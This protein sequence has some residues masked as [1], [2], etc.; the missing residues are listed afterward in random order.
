LTDSLTS[1]PS[2]WSRTL[3]GVAPAILL[4]VVA[5]AVGPRLGPLFRPLFVAGCGAA[6]WYAWRSGPYAH[7]QAALFLF[8]FAPLARRIVDVSAG[9]DPTGLML[10]GP[11]LAIIVPLPQLRHYLEDKNAMPP[12]MTPIL[13]TAGCVAYAAAISLFQGDWFNAASGTLKWM[14][15]LVYASALLQYADRE[16]L[17]E[18]MTSAFLVILPITGLIGIYQYIDPPDW[19]RYWMQFAPILSVGR[20]LPYEVRV[21]S[22]MNG[23]ATFATFTAT[24]LLLVCFLRPR[25]YLPL[26][27]IPA[28][29]AFLLSLYRTAWLSLAVGVLFCL[30]FQSM[31]RRAAVIMLGAVGAVVIA[32][33][34]PPFA[35]V[36]GE[37]L[38]TL[39]EGAGD[40]SA[41]ERLE[42]YVTLWN[43]SDSSLFG[44]GFTTGD[45]GSAGTVATDGMIISC[46]QAMGIVIGLFC[47]SALVWVCLKMVA[48]AW[49]DG[50]REATIIGALGCGALV[51][52]PL[53]NVTSSE[54][55]FLFWTFAALAMLE[56]SV[57][58]KSGVR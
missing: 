39:A 45:V 53:A 24:G 43:Q 58:A 50:R 29:L 16:Q 2:N 32:A 35:D 55:G 10:I 23:P 48:A 46:W 21:F 36:V 42:Q 41:R 26:A 8:A 22:T 25:W 57:P 5:I 34:L 37:R 20:P 4:L 11:L 49:R 56:P 12:G 28:A 18:A 7:V 52:L 27:A 30:L 13:V 19:D 3:P 44:I 38:G 15:P 51:Q 54:L 31:R 47:L 40:D 17:V 6:G 9:Y 1:V 14:A 33:T